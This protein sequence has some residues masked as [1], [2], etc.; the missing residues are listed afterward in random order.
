M[1]GTT[2]KEITEVRVTLPS[3]YS[4]PKTDERSHDRGV[5]KVNVDELFTCTHI[6]GEKD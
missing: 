5:P 6:P 4:R 2:F 1:C 3:V